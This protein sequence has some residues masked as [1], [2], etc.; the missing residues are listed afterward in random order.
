MSKPDNEARLARIRSDMDTVMSDAIRKTL[1]TGEE[2]GC[3]FIFEDGAVLRA[4]F[5]I[6]VPTKH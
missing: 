3:E 5:T 4:S 6:H 2:H 1:E